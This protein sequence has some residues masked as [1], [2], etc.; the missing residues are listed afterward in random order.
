MRLE[1]DQKDV[2]RVSTESRHEASWRLGARAG[3]RPSAKWAAAPL[4]LLDA[5]CIALCMLAAYWLRFDV[6]EYNAALSRSFYIRLIVMAVPVWV[7]IFALRRLYHPDR[8]FGGLQE[9]SEVFMACTLGLVSLI[10]FSFLVRSVEQ[11]IS[12]GW[13]A[14]VWLSSIASVTWTRFG[15]RRLI[16]RLRQEGLFTRRAVVVGANAEG[17]SVAAQLRASPKAGVEVVGFIDPALPSGS[18]VEGVPVLGSAEQLDGLVQELDIEKFI[19]IPTALR[20]EMLLEIYRDWGTDERI[21]MCLSSGLYELFTTGVQV[22]EVAFVPLVHLNRTRITGIDAVMKTALDYVGTAVAILLL[23]PFLLAI[24]LLV[25]LDSPGPIIYRRRVIG[26]HGKEFDAFKF[27]TMICDADAHLEA[28]PEL[29]TEWERTG[30]IKD[31]PRITGAGRFLRRFSLDELPQLFNILRGEMSLVGPRMVTPAELAH[32]NHWRHNRLTV[33]P[34]LTGLWQVSGR[35]DLSYED[36]VLLD[37]HYIR[38]YTI[39]LDLKALFDTLGAVI[40][41]RGAY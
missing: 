31:D 21:S 29:K 14:L 15:Y 1:T 23:S 39:W 12:R 20:R 8:L 35:S 33:K 6:L 19:I 3:W 36:R 26:L 17:R 5:F 18:E 37:T 28:H 32:F 16:Y 2:W 9:Y 30:K 4:I 7:I 22:Q 40:R 11:D 25:R 24:A 41:G 27:R 13:L 10:L 38:N 34:G